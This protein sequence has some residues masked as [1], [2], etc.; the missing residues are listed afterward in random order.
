MP[1]ATITNTEELPVVLTMKHL[2]EITGL[3][4][5]KCYEL[6]HIKGFPSIRFG[7]AIRIPRDKF[8][9]WLEEQAQEG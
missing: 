8:L 5:P 7:R 9:Q 2:Q 1:A 6:P 4:R 3:S